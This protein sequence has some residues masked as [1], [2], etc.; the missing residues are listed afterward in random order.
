[1]TEQ[2]QA[3]G[4]MTAAV[5]AAIAV[6]SFLFAPAHGHQPP[7]GP[8]GTTGTLAQG[9]WRGVRYGQRG[10]GG[11]PPD[12]NQVMD[13]FAPSLSPSQVPAAVMFI[14]G[15][16]WTYGSRNYYRRETREK[17]LER[18]FVF[19]SPEFI[20]QSP[21][22]D[23][24]EKEAVFPAMLADIDLA[25]SRLKTFLSRLG[26]QPAKFIIAG[27]SSGGHLALMYAYDKADPSVLGLGLKHE[28]DYDAAV[29]IASPVDLL[30][31]DGG[32]PSASLNPLDPRLMVR[33]VVKRLVGL[34]D[35]ATDEE[36]IPLVFKWSPVNLV[37]AESTPTI[38]AYGKFPFLSS[39]GIVPSAQMKALTGRLDQ[40]GVK[41]VSRTLSWTRHDMVAAEAA[42]WICDRILDIGASR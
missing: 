12:A 30:T 6:F 3:K 1:M 13:V 28:I 36:L 8:D 31:I 18:G 21:P 38:L 24:P 5:A 17:F 10:G 32:E 37:R 34:A 42:D 19:C 11:L 2:R 40:C 9:E 7:E 27:E 20:L 15:G 26:I 23:P 14:H 33:I 25:T 4:H 22:V 16:M 39:D 41:H 29:G 35:N